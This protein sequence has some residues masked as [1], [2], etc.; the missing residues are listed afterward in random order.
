[1]RKIWKFLKENGGII[2]G[3]IATLAGFILI[4][5]RIID[6][7]RKSSFME[8]FNLGKSQRN[9][10]EEDRSFRRGYNSG[11]SKGYNKGSNE[12]KDSS[13]R[14]G[15]EDAKSDSDLYSRD[16]LDTKCKKSYHVGREHEDQEFKEKTKDLADNIYDKGVE[17]GYYTPGSETYKYSVVGY[18]NGFKEGMK[19]GVEV[20]KTSTL[21]DMKE[22]NI[23]NPSQ[24]FIANNYNVVL[25]KESPENINKLIN[26]NK[27]DDIK[28]MTDTENKINDMKSKS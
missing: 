10:Y 14:K 8:G 20:G 15:Y 19:E 3:F 24:S 27:M 6:S 13:Y 5:L 28:F 17:A 26:E 25:T 7:T 2:F 23:G 1:M 12:M 11:Y 16:E 18:H 9:K 22:P 21:L 4:I